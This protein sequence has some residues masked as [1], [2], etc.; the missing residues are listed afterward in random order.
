MQFNFERYLTKLFQHL[1]EHT[2]QIPISQTDD[3]CGICYPITTIIPPNFQNFYFWY[4]RQY[5]ACNFS[6]KT[7]EYF[8]QLKQIYTQLNLSQLKNIIFKLIFSIRYS[9]SPGNILDIIK[10]IASLAVYTNCY[11]RN[12][13]TLIKED[14]ESPYYLDFESYSDSFEILF[15]PQQYIL[16]PYHLDFEDYSDSFEILFN[17]Q[18]HMPNLLHNQQI[19]NIMTTAKDVLD[20]LKDNEKGGNVL[21][22]ES[23]HGDG[24]QDPLACT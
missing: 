7:I 15:N 13:F 3:S 19:Q 17:P 1:K 8:N 4:T 6:A 21:H 10:S 16:N 18:Q 12:P 9:S 20:F 2:N 24:T 14:F 22:I 11:Q 23:F 5:S